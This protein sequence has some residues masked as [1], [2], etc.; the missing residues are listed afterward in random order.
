MDAPF[1]QRYRTGDLLAHAT[2]DIS[3]LQRVAGNGVLQLFDAI[4]S[5]V[6]VMIAMGLVI[7]P[8]LTLFAVMPLF[9]IT[10]MAYGLG[11]RIHTAFTNAQ[12]AFSRLN[13]KAQESIMGIKALRTLGQEAE[14]IAD[15]EQQ[16]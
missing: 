11:G 8:W 5:G 13:N 10:G 12:D 7:N 1:F 9:G 14:D 2:N 15:F 16:V 3:Q 4:M 6:L